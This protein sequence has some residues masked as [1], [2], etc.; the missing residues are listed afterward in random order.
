MV[1]KILCLIVLVAAVSASAETSEGDN[2]L[3]SALKMVKDCGDKSMI[4]CIKERAL[5]YF[6]TEDGDVKLTEGIQLIKTDDIPQGRS[7][8]DV[9]LPNEPEARE[10]EVDSLLVER[11]ARFFG[12]HTLQFKVPKESIEDMQRSLEESRGKKKKT[13]KY[14]MPLLLLFKL[15]AAALLPL[16]I[17][18]LALIAFKALIIGK[19][20][21]L[22]SGII[23]VKKLLES[24]NSS[25]NYEVVA[26]PHY[27]A[28]EEHGSYARSLEAQ[29][30]AYSAYQKT[31]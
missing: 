31:N 2:L 8:N 10:S 13:K 25:Q 7:L 16:A 29:N 19:I 28:H 6:D 11:I 14:L 9:D 4:L 15:K 17:G 26:H 27:S 20:A 23:G 12:T 3:A 30:L 5:Q 22:L 21:L 24:K 1:P 18:F